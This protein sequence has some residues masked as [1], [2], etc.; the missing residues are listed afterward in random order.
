[1]KPQYIPNHDETNEDIDEDLLSVIGSLCG[2]IKKWS[3]GDQDWEKF[4]PRL[5]LNVSRVLA[6]IIKLR[7]VSYLVQKKCVGI[8]ELR[9]VM[10]L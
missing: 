5:Q 6:V 10:H 2:S 8:F 4:Q 7:E 9:H 3:R 1:M